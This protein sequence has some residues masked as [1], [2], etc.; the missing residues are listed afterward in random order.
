MTGWLHEVVVTVVPAALAA[1]T[2]A[3]LQDLPLTLDGGGGGVAPK[4]RHAVV[5]SRND[6]DVSGPGATRRAL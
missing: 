5:L 4:V 3:V 2:G 6:A 1:F